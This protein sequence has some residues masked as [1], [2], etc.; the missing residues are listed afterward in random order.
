LLLR[1]AG[2]EQHDQSRGCKQDS[3]YVLCHWVLLILL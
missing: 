1:Q 3:F 2:C